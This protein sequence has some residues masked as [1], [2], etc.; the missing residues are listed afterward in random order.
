MLAYQNGVN[1]KGRSFDSNPNRKPFYLFLPDK[2][3]YGHDTVEI[4]SQF[5]RLRRQ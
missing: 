5:F 3:A 2:Q 4:I 1:V